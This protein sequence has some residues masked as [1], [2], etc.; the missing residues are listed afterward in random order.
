MIFLQVG[1]VPFTPIHF[2]TQLTTTIPSFS[3]AESKSANPSCPQAFPQS[4][5][6]NPLLPIHQIIVDTEEKTLHSL[7]T[8]TTPRHIIPADSTG[9]GNNFSHGYSDDSGTAATLETLRRILESS[10]T[11]SSQGTLLIHSI[12]GGTGSGL[13]SRLAEEMRDA[14]PKRFLWSVSVSPFIGGETCLQ[15]YNSVLAVA[16]VQENAD[17][18]SMVGNDGVMGV[19]GRQCAMYR[20]NKMDAKISLLDLN[21]Q[22][23]ASLAGVLMPTSPAVETESGDW[24]HLKMRAFN[25]WDLVTQVAPMPCC[26]LVS[27][28]TSTNVIETEK[29]VGLLKGLIPPP[30][31]DDVTSDLLRNLPPAP[32]SVKRS[33]IS[34]RLY[35]RNALGPDFLS[36]HQKLHSKLKLKLGPSI[37]PAPAQDL[38]LVVSSTY[39]ISPKSNTRSLT[40]VSNGSENIAM[41]GNL[42]DRSMSMYESGAYLHWYAR[43]WGDHHEEAR[44]RVVGA[45]KVKKASR[46]GRKT[47][48][49][50]SSVL[51]ASRLNESE[52]DLFPGDEEPVHDAFPWPY[53]NR[54][55]KEV[56]T[57]GD[58]DVKELF[59][60][61]F[62]VVRG[63]LDSY[64]E[65]CTNI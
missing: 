26:K 49:W 40:L 15:W 25:G 30:S 39:A 16:K 54:G 62:E 43:Y 22:I 24:N 29:R 53:G 64:T 11:P 47:G 41:L 42:L 10:S 34:S 31:W 55:G 58:W 6:P 28:A 46:S 19:V 32:V 51:E 1:Q 18:V 9:R 61:S 60:D 5:H 50:D 3:S 37:V 2:H 12:A 48:G 36:H 56:W 33:H 63:M 8:P 14:D 38:E 23:A 27:I 7:P 57:E 4:S 59:E 20:G 65:F 45:S 13:G 44:R 35:A 17:V 21:A 52:R